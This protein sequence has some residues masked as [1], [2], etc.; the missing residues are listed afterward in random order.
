MSRIVPFLLLS[1]LTLLLPALQPTSY[2]NG[3]IPQGL[4]G[5]SS[6]I[7]DYRIGLDRECV[8]SVTVL[9]RSENETAI[10]WILIPKIGTDFVTN[11]SVVRIDADLQGRGT[12]SLYWN[13]SV[14][15]TPGAHVVLGYSFPNAC[16]VLRGRAVFLSPLLRF[17]SGAR[18]SVS[19]KVQW[20]GA[21]LTEVD[22]TP[23]RVTR[24]A[25][26]F[27]VERA[28]PL[29]SDRLSFTFSVPKEELVEVKYGPLT[30]VL[31]DRYMWVAERLSAFY[32]DFEGNLTELFPRSPERVRVTFFLPDRYDEGPEGY[33]SLDG[34][35]REG[36]ASLNLFLLRMVD[37]M[38]EV[39]FMHELVHRYLLANGVSAGA[40]WFHEGLATYLSVRMAGAAGLEA[41]PYLRA[42]F[43]RYGVTASDLKE[44]MA[45]RPGESRGSRW[46]A[47]AY[48]AFERLFET[49]RTGVVMALRSLGRS[50][51]ATPEDAA[52]HL[53]DH[54]NQEGKRFLIESGLAIKGSD[55]L[56]QGIGTEIA[57]QSDRNSTYA[58]GGEIENATHLNHLLANVLVITVVMVTL[59]IVLIDTRRA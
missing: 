25:D 24:L 53:F 42:M 58:G 33:V 1:F 30:F 5:S 29:T 59:A 20:P 51:L 43:D 16:L 34:D 54:L 3:S 23:S 27:V 44:L 57:V 8:A 39:T 4:T 19:V 10:A 52:E 49:D 17:P 12:T 26:G 31:P 40:T 11:G 2:A 9:L 15:L 22:A 13:V 37:G 35:G 28:L 21:S 55:M 14:L 46:Y 38:L 50:Q 18:G 48:F 7:Y 6:I 32:A 36:S 41:A 45:W 47:M 56:S